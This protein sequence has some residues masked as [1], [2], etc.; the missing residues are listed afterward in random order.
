MQFAKHWAATLDDYAIDLSWSPD[1]ATLAAASA[2]GG[3]TL[4]DAA[5]GEV[6]HT[7][8]GH[9]DGANCLAW[10]PGVAGVADPG[11]PAVGRAKDGPGS[12]GPAAVLTTG[13]QDGCVRFWDACTG[14]QTS[15]VKLGNA[16]VEHLAWS[17][18]G[19]QLAPRQALGPELVE[20]AGAESGASQLAGPLLFA[21]SGKKLVALNPDGS[22]AHQFPDAPKTISALACSPVAG[23]AD[24]GPASTRPATIPAIAA[25]YFGGVCVWDA[26][27][28]AVHKE[29][30]YGN[31][32]YALTWSPDGRW[33]V[34]G[35]HDNAVH[36]WVPAED[37]ELHMSGYETRLKE[38]SFSQ[39][40]K[41]LATGGGKDVCVWDC[42]GAGPEGREPLQLP[43]TVRTTAVAFQNQH[44]LLATGDAAGTFTLWG[45]TRKNPMVAEVKMPSAATKFAWSPDDTLLAVGTEKGA[46]YV[47]TTA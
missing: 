37:L 17:A 21:A 8:P 12:P 25:A 28:F 5:T 40:S 29:F 4:Y 32:I 35:C 7:L 19:R 27:T 9:A 20:R 33:L 24:P 30:P 36:L 15:E 22:L 45:P 47:F 3:I 43:Q 18:V 42:T 46:V 38:L 41:W 26:A 2:A 39:D 6:K 14:G 31:A 16:W 1:G 34:A 13:G 23:V 10:M 44:S 11:L